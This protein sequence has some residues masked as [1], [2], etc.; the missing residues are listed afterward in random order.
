M[1]F[2]P[3]DKFDCPELRKFSLTKQ[4]EGSCEC[5]VSP[6]RLYKHP[7]SG[8][9]DA[10][11][12]Q[13]IYDERYQH[14]NDIKKYDLELNTYIDC[15]RVP[16]FDY[17]SAI[18]N[19]QNVPYE[20]RWYVKGKRSTFLEFFEQVL[21]ES[22]QESSLFCFTDL[23]KNDFEIFYNILPPRILTQQ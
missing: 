18:I 9:Y 16:G 7:K 14:Y 20:R 22:E 12:F 6:S 5:L 15:L 19:K 1:I 11:L 2:V 4:L 8:R 21:S 13:I 3:E 17:I 23:C 10:T